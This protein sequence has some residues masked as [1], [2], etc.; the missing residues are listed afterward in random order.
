MAEKQEPKL[1][2]VQQ[3]IKV[4]ERQETIGWIGYTQRPINARTQTRNMYLD[5]IKWE[6]DQQIPV[7]SWSWEWADVEWYTYTKIGNYDFTRWNTDRIVIPSTWTYMIIA[8]FIIN[9][10]YWDLGLTNYKI[11][12]N[13]NYLL[14]DWRLA[15]TSFESLNITWI[16]NLSK[17]D[18]IKMKINIDSEA[19]IRTIKSILSITKLS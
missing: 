16:E 2:E 5:S 19:N 11:T 15:M 17:W 9:D 12:K 1:Q 8:R 18:I 4:E 14:A 3:S 7:P 10:L 13:G 6:S